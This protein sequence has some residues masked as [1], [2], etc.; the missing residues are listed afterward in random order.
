VVA[1]ARSDSV[2]AL[3]NAD[4]VLRYDLR[5]GR[6]L[7]R[8]AAID[9]RQVGGITAMAMDEQTLWVGGPLGLF[10]VQ[11]GT[12]TARFHPAPIEIAGP[13]NEIRLTREYAWIATSDGVMRL[14]RN[15][16]GT[17]P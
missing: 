9:F 12:E 13:V 11:R 7:P 5:A 15:S 1:F 6:L 4:E 16:D 8:F 2:V 17:L 10:V 3:A 14:R